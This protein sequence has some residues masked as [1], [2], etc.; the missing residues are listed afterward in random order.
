MMKRLRYSE[1]LARRGEYDDAVAR[2]PD[3]AAFCS[4]SAWILAARACLRPGEAEES[5]GAPRLREA[6]PDAESGV[7]VAT[8][9]ETGSWLVFRRSDEGYWQ[10]FEG[11]WLFACPLAGPDPAAT[12]AFLE[13]TGRALAMTGPAAFLVGGVPAGGSLHRALSD[14]GRRARRHVEFPATDCMTID[15][16]DGVGGWLAR[17]SR[18][19]RRSLAAAEN[20]RAAAGI[21]IAPAPP[22]QTPDDLFARLMAVQGRTEKWKAG[23]DIFHHA[24]CR[25]F[26]RELLGDL[27]ESGALR[28]LFARRGGEDIAHIF[29]GV[30]PGT[31]RGLQMSYAAEWSGVGVGNALQ[32]ENLRRSAAEGVTLYDLGM[33]SDYKERWADRRR[34]LLGVFLAFG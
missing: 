11:S 22:D 18:K 7:F 1:F 23:T 24:D 29:G 25:D 12:V 14:A 32:L 16:S 31:Y 28:L 8:E 20:R 6:G 34:E 30:F 19:F 10:P 9:P 33:P 4:A 27:R 2:T 5:G 17:R 3:V 26:Y 13:K 15:L 21:E